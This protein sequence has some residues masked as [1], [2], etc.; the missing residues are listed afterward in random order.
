M[1]YPGKRDRVIRWEVMCGQRRRRLAHPTLLAIIALLAIAPLA[2]AADAVVTDAAPV[3]SETTAVDASTAP[4]AAD[5][6]PAPAPDPVPVPDP[7]PA[8]APVVEVPPAPAPEPAPVVDP[9]VVVAPDPVPTTLEPIPMPQPETALPRTVAAPEPAAAIDAIAPRPTEVIADVATAAPAAVVE[10]TEADTQVL[11]SLPQVPLVRLADASA[12][13]PKAPTPAQPALPA[14]LD[15]NPLTVSLLAPLALTVEQQVARSVR[16]PAAEAVQAT[17]P[18]EIRV[19]F[20]F[21]GPVS[22]GGGPVDDASRIA[23]LLAYVIGL[24]PMA[25]SDGR[26]TTGPPPT[27]AIL[28]LGAAV[29]AF[30]F[31]M[32]PLRDRRRTGPRGFATLSLRPG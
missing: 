7:V 2:A 28:A 31:L 24:T 12:S 8:P 27:L 11:T 6:A 22:R 18:P 23:D 32:L 25:P 13:R 30:A 17:P 1:G 10:E 15:E 14:V 20:T 19:P 3:A 9:V 21:V 16:E 4:P 29:A 26:V 5:T